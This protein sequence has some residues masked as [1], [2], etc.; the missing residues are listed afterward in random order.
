MGGC[1]FGFVIMSVNKVIGSD[2]FVNTAYICLSG[3]RKLL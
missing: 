2:R 3:N 1:L